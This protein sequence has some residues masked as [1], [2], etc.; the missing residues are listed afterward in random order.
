VSEARERLKRLLLLVPYVARHPGI[1]VDALAERLD[2][3]RKVLLDEL[4]LLCLVGKPPFQPDDYIDVAVENDRVWVHLDARFSAPPRFTA[5]E[6]VSLAAAARLLAPGGGEV[7]R[8]ALTRLEE[9]LPPAAR[10]S[11]QEL[12]SKLDTRGAA[13]PELEELSRALRERRVVTFDYLTPGRERAERRRVQPQ[14]LE[15]LFGHWYLTG[16]DEGRGET[17]QFRL[18]RLSGL[19]VTP[20]PATPLVPERRSP[21]RERGGQLARIRVSPAA[22]PYLRERFGGE[23]LRLAD[24]GLEVELPAE[25]EAWLVRWVLSWAG[26]AEVLSPPSA[27]TAVARAARAS[28]DSGP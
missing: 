20:E 17:R 11:Y 26:E 13:P 7:L 1:T 10:T 8:G 23:A 18:D 15:A 4:D 12:A 25:P 9:A 21:R 16:L 19:A 14:T 6:A 24:G 3:P 28:L 22:A 27:R 5:P 2:V